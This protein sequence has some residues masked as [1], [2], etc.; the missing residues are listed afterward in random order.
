M[1]AIVAT[2]AACFGGVYLP[3][4]VTERSVSKK[5]AA[6]Y[7]LLVAVLKVHGSGIRSGVTFWTSVRDLVP[8]PGQVRDYGLLNREPSDDY[9]Q[10]KHYIWSWCFRAGSRVCW[11]R[12][13]G[14]EMMCAAESA[15]LA[16]VTE[17]YRKQARLLDVGG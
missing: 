17:V 16:A 5:E 6:A 2:A 15:L 9:T 10:Q 1:G 12:S 13:G 7:S 11:C 14:T 8:K 4:A 3:L